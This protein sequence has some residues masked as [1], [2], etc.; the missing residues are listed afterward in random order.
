MFYYEFNSIQELAV[1]HSFADNVKVWKNKE[2]FKGHVGDVSE[3]L[4]IS[5]SGKKNSPN[6][7]YVYIIHF[8][9]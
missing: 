7:Y 2:A 3:F 9:L 5:L 1:R 4:R 8:F 6:L